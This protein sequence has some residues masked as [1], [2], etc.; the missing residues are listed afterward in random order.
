MSVSKTGIIEVNNDWEGK[1]G[2]F[3]SEENML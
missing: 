1:V 2:F 3:S